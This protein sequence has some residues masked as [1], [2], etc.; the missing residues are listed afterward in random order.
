MHPTNP[1]AQDA[2]QNHPQTPTQTSAMLLALALASVGLAVFQTPT[3][4]SPLQVGVAKIDITP[5]QPVTMSGY[6]SRKGLSQGVHDP[7]FARVTAFEQ[8]GHRL[9]LISTDVLG[10]YGTSA[11]I[12]R[13]AIVDQ[14]Q[15]QPAELYLAAIHTHSAPTVTFDAERGH[16]NNIAYSKTLQTKLIKAVREALAGLRPVQVGFAFGSS[17]VGANRRQVTQDTNGTPKIIL[18]RNPSA[19]TDRQV[20]VIELLSAQEEVPMGVLFGY[21]THSTSLGPGN[22]IISGDVHGLAEQF[23]EKYLDRGLI[24]AGFAGTSGDIDPWFRI[25]PSFNT[26]NGWI[27]E[28]VLL[29]TLLGE[30]VVHVLEQVHNATNSG[31]VKSLLRTVQMPGKPKVE[32]G[33]TNAPTVALNITVGRVGSIA[34]VGLGGEV[35]N[36]IGQAIKAASPFPCTF[37]MTHC[38]GSAGYLPTR[39]SY[40]A[41]GYEV[42]SSPFAAGAAELIPQY[43]S[44][45][46][47]ELK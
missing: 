27:P 43:V 45:M 46:L 1:D 7:L 24:T 21:A 44:E 22:Y 15:L 17:P 30:E 34:F 41:G 31:P 14:C 36:E 12:M 25:L 20:Q 47:A 8:D 23:I 4:A 11:R 6:D 16:S 28:P 3:S 33:V 9:V 26:T 35:F 29:G 18:G 32:E 13:E 42:Q 19:M 40:D 37:V 5:T 39:P 10:Y 38:N 2:D